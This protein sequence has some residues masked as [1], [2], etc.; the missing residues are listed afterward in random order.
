MYEMR[1]FNGFPSAP[2]EET[3]LLVIH[4]RA[5]A[6]SDKLFILRRMVDEENMETD[7]LGLL[8]AE[9]LLENQ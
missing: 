6:E 3:G 5:Q 7:A 4:V 1:T 9:A 2:T 8:L